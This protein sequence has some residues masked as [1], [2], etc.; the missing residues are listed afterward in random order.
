MVRVDS[1]DRLLPI[2]SWVFR[3]AQRV[4][5]LTRCCVTRLRFPALQTAVRRKGNCFT[6]YADP[7]LG[8]SS[9]I[10]TVAMPTVMGSCDDPCDSLWSTHHVGPMDL[11]NQFQEGI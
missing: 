5:C 2:R 8:T 11:E 7:C 3:A 6:R 10:E 9:T 1:L 4:L